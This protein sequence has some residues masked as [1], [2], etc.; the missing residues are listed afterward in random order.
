MQSI[1][2]A[3]VPRMYAIS[4]FGVSGLFIC[5]RNEAKERWYSKGY[6]VESRKIHRRRNKKEI[7]LIES[8]AQEQSRQKQLEET[9]RCYKR[10]SLTDDGKEVLKDLEFFCG[11]N[12]TSA[13]AKTY[14]A[15]EMFFREGARNVYLHIR[16]HLTRKTGEK[17]G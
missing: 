1:A 14:D 17:N 4:N 5:G 3:D 11:F 12:R 2:G 8:E 16:N 9:S 15:N 7:Q 6:G 13:N 10:M